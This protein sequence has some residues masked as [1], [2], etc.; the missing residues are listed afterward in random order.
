[1]DLVVGQDVCPLELGL[2]SVMGREEC[3]VYWLTQ[4]FVLLGGTVSVS[5]AAKLTLA[6]EEW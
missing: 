6:S 2:L 4:G 5:A 1:V 3:F